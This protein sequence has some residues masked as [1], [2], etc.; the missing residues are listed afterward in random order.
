MALR[1]FPSDIN[2]FVFFVWAAMA[3]YEQ[4]LKHC[5]VIIYNKSHCF[6]KILEYLSFCLLHVVE[7]QELKRDFRAVT[8]TI[9]KK[10]YM[11]L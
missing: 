9:L 8:P 2:R 7:Q 4:T 6:N 11:V 10:T 5:E 1:I 3:D